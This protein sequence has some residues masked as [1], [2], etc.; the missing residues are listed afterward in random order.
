MSKKKNGNTSLNMNIFHPMTDTQEDI[1]ASY[2]EGYQLFLHGTAGTGKT[3][4]AMSLAL[5]SVLNAKVH[6]KIVVIRS[7][8][9]SRDMGFAPGSIEEKSKL[10]EGPYSQICNT[11]FKRGDGYDIIKNKGILEFIPTSYIRGKTFQNCFIIVDEIQN[12]S[13]EELNT[14]ITRVGKN[15]RIVMCGD[16]EQTDLVKKHDP[17]GLPEFMKIIKNM[18]SF[19]VLDFTINDIVRSG[20][21]KEYIEAKEGIQNKTLDRVEYV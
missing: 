20:L 2:K 1:L 16:T 18:A 10:Y 3:Y 11:I 9:P 5:N 15:C 19:E 14:I 21:V 13:F 4:C 8:V 6:N 7:A 12:M 17:S